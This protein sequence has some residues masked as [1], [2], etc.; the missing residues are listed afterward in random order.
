MS[1]DIVEEIAVFVE[2]SAAE[3]GFKE[4][5]LLLNALCH[6]VVCRVVAVH[7]HLLVELFGIII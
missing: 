6:H 4:F 7:Q 2:E 1:V 5:A 3:V